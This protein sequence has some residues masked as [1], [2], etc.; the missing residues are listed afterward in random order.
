MAAPHIG[1][2]MGIMDIELRTVS[3][4]LLFIVGIMALEG[5]N[6]GS[7]HLQYMW[8]NEEKGTSM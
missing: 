2:I 3:L 5:Y 1:C 8:I 6:I 7:K 4:R